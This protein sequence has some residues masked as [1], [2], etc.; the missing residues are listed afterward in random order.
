MI[1]SLSTSSRWRLLRSL[2]VL[3]MLT[4]ALGTGRGVSHA[5]SGT[6]HFSLMPTFA[7]PYNKVPRAYF[8]YDSTLGS[9]ISDSIHVTNDGTATGT[10]SLY[11]TDAA[12][13]QTSG[14]TFL[15][16]TATRHDVGAWITLSS[17]AV[18]LKPGQS[19]DVPFTLIIPKSER[20]GQHGGGIV[21]ENAN[22]LL[23]LPHSRSNIIRLNLQSLT[24]LGVLVNL[25]GL[26]SEQMIAGGI[27]Y[28]T[29]SQYQRLLISLMNMGTQLLAPSGYLQVKDDQGQL[30]QNLTL[31]LRT[32]LP[33]TSINYPV[34]IQ[35]KVL[36][37]GKKYTAIL[38]L[39][40]GHN[41]VLSYK[42][43][44]STV[45]ASKVQFA[46]LAQS[47]IVAPNP[48]VNK[49]NLRDYL[50]IIVG[51]FLGLS[52]LFFWGKKIA[53]VVSRRLQKS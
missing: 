37:L 23:A 2:F 4:I 31:N 15:S 26:T 45:V 32:F 18:T 51:G 42:T 29:K 50:I 19:K 41:H 40:Y 52:A 11:A 16:R 39:N 27:S 3:S 17:T 12:T 30:V 13:A 49:L 35:N 33:L 47:M 5:D 25:P 43:T 28:D 14:T 24:A 21:A 20:A 6:A 9:R 22:Q 34:Y 48:T 46:T 44:F 38:L 1:A 36:P 53:D 8:I 10:V 7:P